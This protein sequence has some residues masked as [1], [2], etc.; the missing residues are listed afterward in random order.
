MRNLTEFTV[1]RSETIFVM[2][3]SHL[4]KCFDGLGPQRRRGWF[5]CG[6][7]LLALQSTAA[8]AD[9]FTN[10]VAAA[11]GREDPKLRA[12][13]RA[14][15]EILLTGPAGELSVFLDHVRAECTKRPDSCDSAIQGFVKNVATAAEM[16]ELT[17]FNTENIFPIIRPDDAGPSM[18]PIVGEDPTK[19]FVSRPYI[20]GAVLMYAIDTPKALRFVNAGDLGKAGLTLQALDKIAMSHVSKLPPVDIQPMEGARGLWT[21]L[22]NDGYA[23]SRLF[24]PK[25]WDALESHVGGPA[26]VALPTRD[27]ILAVR[28]D[29]AEAMTRLRSL[30]RRVVAGEPR[31]VTASLVRRDGAGWAEIPP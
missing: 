12:T 18:K 7:V 22:A 23:T 16:R 17:A 19:L 9:A 29:D 8:F 31:A 6:V 14:D 25:F 2:E 30:A 13:V 11:F 28:L 20:S 4:M 26:A 15:D 3:Q 24:D 5:A 1:S 21:A 27:W 10:R